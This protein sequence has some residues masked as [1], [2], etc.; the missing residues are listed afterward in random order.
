M[1]VYLLVT[2]LV[3]LSGVLS[4]VSFMLL[5]ERR[6]LRDEKSAAERAF[7]AE[8]NDM[9]QRFFEERL[10]LEQRFSA[11]R[12]Q[13]EQRFSEERLQLEQRARDAEHESVTLSVRLENAEAERHAS[14]EAFQLRFKNLAN[15]ILSEQTRQF[16][17]TNRDELDKLLKPFKDNISEFRA[18]VEHIYSAENEQRGTLRGELNKLLELNRRITDETSNLT[19]ALKG[20]SK[21]QGDL[22]EMLLETILENSNLVRGQH[23]DTQLN[24]KDEAGNNLRPDV[25]LRLP[26]GKRIVIDSKMSLTAYAD[27]VSSQDD[28]SRDRA[29]ASHLASVRRHVQELSDK[30]YHR[31]VQSPEFVIMFVPSEAAFLSAVQNDST[32]WSDAYRR[33]VI[34]SSPTNL[35]AVLKLVDDLWRRSEQNRNTAR[36]VEY[37]TKLYDQLTQFVGALE[38]VGSAL[39]KARAGYDEAYKRLCT[40]NDNIIRSGERLR[41]LGLPVKRNQS[42]RALELSAAADDADDAN[43]NHAADNADNADNAA[44]DRA[45]NA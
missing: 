12:L 6:R 37:G 20:D 18:R 9:E 8:R 22:G 29:L 34:I 35:F 13:L 14:D 25:V 3:L 43:A 30:E 15:D 44:A 32:L 27:Y 5:R 24:I 26:E 1:N 17:E 39:D 19:R 42:P 28:A 7:A 21:M 11:E 23:Y 31:L 10:Q 45:D 36:I 2:L 41:K 38:S 33:K 40:G 16:R 4:A